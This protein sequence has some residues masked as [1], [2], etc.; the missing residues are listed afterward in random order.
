MSKQTLDDLYQEYG[1]AAVERALRHLET[2]PQ[3]E[4]LRLILKAREM[5]AQ[6]EHLKLCERE[7]VAIRGLV[8]KPEDAISLEQL[9]FAVGSPTGITE[10]VKARMEQL[11]EI[12]DVLAGFQ[13]TT[14]SLVE[15]VRWLRKAYNAAWDK[16]HPVKRNDED[17]EAE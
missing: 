5:E 15:R 11:A 3:A 13:S 9:A 12:E 6:Q 16:L 2:A 7:I 10:A 8:L 1:K 17:D 14:P 4:M